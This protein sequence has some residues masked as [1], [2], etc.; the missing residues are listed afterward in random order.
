MLVGHRDTHFQFLKDLQPGDRLEIVG[1]DGTIRRYK[2]T[3]QQVMDSRQG[4]IATSDEREELILVTC[5]PFDAITTGGPL[6][7]V[8]R[9]E[10]RETP[11]KEA[12]AKPDA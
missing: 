2:V 3:E 10:L 4:N 11:F 12:A 7:Y 5:F 6:R 8:V 9:A 1:T